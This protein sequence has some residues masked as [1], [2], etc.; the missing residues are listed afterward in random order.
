[1]TPRPVGTTVD[2]TCAFRM[3]P[4]DPFDERPSSAM[5]MRVGGGLTLHYTWVHPMDGGQQGVLLV[6]A[7]PD[8][9]PVEATLVDPAQPR[10]K[11]R[12]ARTPVVG[13]DHTG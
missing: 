7:S 3:M 12:R 4:A 6:G 13:T 8:E 10:R 9:G 1:M 2:G 11:R 5:V